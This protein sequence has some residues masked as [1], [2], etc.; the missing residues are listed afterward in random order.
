MQ[1]RENADGQVEYLTFRWTKTVNGRV[2]RCK[3]PYP[4][5]LPVQ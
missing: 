3:R 2:I 5:W 4:L 1:Y